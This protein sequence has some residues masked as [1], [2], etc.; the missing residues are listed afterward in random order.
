MR[1]YAVDDEAL[2]LDMLTD[3]IREAY[4][5]AELQRFNN[6]AE[7]LEKIKKEPCDVLFTDIQ[8]PEM[9]GLEFA[10]KCQ[11]VYSRMNIIF[12]TAYDNYALQAF[13]MYASGYLQKPVTAQKIQKEMQHLRF[14]LE[15]AQQKCCRIQCYGMFEI[16]DRQNRPVHFHRSKSKEI[17]AYLTH[18]RG[19]FCTVRQIAA[20]LFEDEPYDIKQTRYMQKLIST[21]LSDLEEHH[22]AGVVIREYNTLAVDTNLV[23]CDYFDNP[24]CSAVLMNGG[25]YMSQ[26]SWAEAMY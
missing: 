22:M 16:F 19:A 23:S 13:D 9:G 20:I 3:A 14:S 6:P 18:C 15:G 26:Y 5:Q 1:L 8:M 21:L 24:D 10:E 2:A 12:V 4:P 7:C 25:E 11:Q 17:L